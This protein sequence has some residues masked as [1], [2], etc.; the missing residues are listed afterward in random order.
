M[1]MLA[2]LLTWIGVAICADILF[3]PLQHLSVLLLCLDQDLY[4]LCSCRP[5]LMSVDAICVTPVDD[6]TAGIG[7]AD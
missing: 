5:L 7:D 2:L 4:H 1:E 6:C 3:L